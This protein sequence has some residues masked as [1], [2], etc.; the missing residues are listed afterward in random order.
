MLP[1]ARPQSMSSSVQGKRASV[2]TDECD[3]VVGPIVRLHLD[4]REVAI[5]I[6]L[7]E[8]LQ[9][10]DLRQDHA[11]VRSFLRRSNRVPNPVLSR[12]IGLPG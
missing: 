3:D 1:I 4:L 2:G 5:A 12:R 7:H 10:R 9:L 6:V 11:P 8:L